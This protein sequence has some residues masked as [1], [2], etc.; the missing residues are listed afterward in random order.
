MS[1]LRCCASRYLIAL[2]VFVLLCGVY[3]LTYRG[4]FRSIDELALYCLT[5]SMV[6]TGSLRTPQ[7][8]FSRYHG[9]V[10]RLEPLHPALATPLYWIA[11][12][13]DRLGNIQTAMLLNVWLTAATAGALYSLLV[14]M[15]HPAGS[16]LLA[17]LAYGLGTMAWP[18][19]RTFFREPL[20]ALLLTLALWGGV[21]WRQERHLRY[22]ALLA[23]CLL[24]TPLVKTT[25]VMAWPA[26]ALAFLVE[27]GISR[28]ERVRRLL[29]VA[30]IGVVGLAIG[31]W[32]Y[33]LRTGHLPSLALLDKWSDLREVSR[34]IFGLTLSAGRGVVLFTPLVLPAVWGVP[35]LW[36]RRRAEGVLV[37]A[38]WL[39]VLI[40]Y[41]GYG[42]WYAGMSWGPRFLVPLM[43][44]LALPLAELLSWRRWWTRVAIGVVIALSVAVQASAAMAD[45]SLQTE[46]GAWDNMTDYA[47]SPVVQQFALWRPA[48]FD[49]WWWHGSAPSQGTVEGEIL[50]MAAMPA[51][52]AIVGSV[53]A[54]VWALHRRRRGAQWCLSGAVV[55]LGWGTASLMWHAPAYPVGYPGVVPGELRE[56]AAIVN[57]PRDKPRVIVTVSNEYHLNLLLSSFKG[58]FVHYWFSPLQQSGFESLLYPPLKARELRLIVDRVHL[59]PESSGRELELWLDARL[60]RYFVDWVGD[61]YQVYSYLYPPAEM[62]LR[63]V[64]YRWGAGMRMMAQGITPHVLSPGDPLW[65]ELHFTAHRR[66]PA[67]YDI[68][69]QLLAPDGHFVNGTDGPPQFGGAPTSRWQPGSMVVD[70]RAVFVPAN[71]SPGTYRLVVGF[72]RDGVREQVYDG[73]GHLVGGCVDLGTVDLRR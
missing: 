23:A 5:E 1:G 59:P 18:Y 21:R 24:L 48:N 47:R 31:A 62:P 65:V 34:R 46:A 43:P 63:A 44:L 68:F 17:T 55:C 69:L 49:M 58:H 53:G 60:Y 2:A 16:A 73:D 37:V 20:L 64:D 42:V 10:G 50:W 15:G 57:R 41:G 9:G 72:Y 51:F 11:V 33:A 22:V 28:R 40:G 12:H 8:E 36:Q 25:A 38:A 54:L 39:L 61:G 4:L 27:E 19:S 71:A 70:R 32:M 45:Y 30:A 6:Q 26:F 13:V 14:E 67:D 29:A 52:L 66:P 7:L 35:S 3:L 56:V